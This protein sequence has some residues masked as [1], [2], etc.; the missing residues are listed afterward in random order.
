MLANVGHELLRQLAS[1]VE[2]SEVANDG[3]PGEF[4]GGSV[5]FGGRRGIKV[6]GVFEGSY[7]FGDVASELLELLVDRE[8]GGVFGGGGAFGSVVG[9]HEDLLHGVVI[10]GGGGGAAGPALQGCGHCICWIGLDG[11]VCGE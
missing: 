3:A 5:G 7:G 9:A 10:G 2:L 4:S 11:M 6:E 1:G 8:G